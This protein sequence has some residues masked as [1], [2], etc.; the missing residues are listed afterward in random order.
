MLETQLLMD[1][2]MMTMT[3]GRQHDEKE[4]RQLFTKA[5]FSEYKI[6]KEFGTRVAFEVYP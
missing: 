6:L 1:I 2:G 4:W 3:K 5:G